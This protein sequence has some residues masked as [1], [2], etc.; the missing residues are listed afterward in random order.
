M[1][2]LTKG[3]LY[4]SDDDGD[5]NN[6]EATRC[7]GL[8]VEL[9]RNAARNSEQVLMHDFQEAVSELLGISKE[10][11]LELAYQLDFE[12]EGMRMPGT[13]FSSPPRKNRRRGCLV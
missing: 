7:A 3:L 12:D 1:A 13:L 9:L 5:R 4:L 11:A 2:T 6:A 8:V 10:D